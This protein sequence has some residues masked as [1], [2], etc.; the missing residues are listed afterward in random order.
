MYLS[1]LCDLCLKYKSKRRKKT[2]V[3]L[4]AELRMDR[5]P[6][7]LSTDSVYL[8]EHPERQDGDGQ[9]VEHHG[10]PAGVRLPALHVLGPRP[11]D[12]QV[13]QREG[14]GGQVAVEQQHSPHP[15]IWK[16]QNKTWEQ[17]KSGQQQRQ[18]G[19]FAQGPET[20]A[21][22][23][24]RQTALC[25]P[26]SRRWKLPGRMPPSCCRSAFPKQNYKWRKPNSP[27]GPSH[28]SK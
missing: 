20:L 12:Q 3:R 9:I 8:R 6:F 13:A 2:L 21:A 14:E 27:L 23:S 5:H 24:Q 18:W 15:P 22:I 28:D 4:L 25:T 26:S 11:H 1:H 17:L 19:M 10:A 7:L 16:A